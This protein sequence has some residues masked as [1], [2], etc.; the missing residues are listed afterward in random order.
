M[1]SAEIRV[2]LPGLSYDLRNGGNI[3]PNRVEA[4]DRIRHEPQSEAIADL[5]SALNSAWRKAR[6][7][8]RL[9]AEEL[10]VRNSAKLVLLGQEADQNFYSPVMGLRDDA[11]RTQLSP[12]IVVEMNSFE[13]YDLVA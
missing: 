6:D 9:D 10:E 2:S 13:H 11:F 5:F 8:S 3:R 4:L 12:L 7:D 1:A